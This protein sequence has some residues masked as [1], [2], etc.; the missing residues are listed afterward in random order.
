VSRPAARL[1]SMLICLLPWKNSPWRATKP[2]SL[3]AISAASSEKELS[4]LDSFPLTVSAG[5][6][7]RSKHEERMRAILFSFCVRRT[8]GWGRGGGTFHE[9]RHAQTPPTCWG[10]AEQFLH[11]C[12]HL[13]R[14]CASSILRLLVEPRRQKLRIW[15]LA[16]AN[17]SRASNIAQ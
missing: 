2:C 10:L 16:Y 1:S 14:G 11:L 6:A 3:K 9:R 13:L 12:L 4:N 17:L 5:R 7:P 15:R 8:R